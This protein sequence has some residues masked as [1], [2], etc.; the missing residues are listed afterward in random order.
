MKRWQWLLICLSL[1]LSVLVLMVLFWPK[2]IECC[3]HC[4]CLTKPEP[5]SL[6]IEDDKELPDAT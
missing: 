5:Q 6:S 4:S 2:I 3:R 1:G